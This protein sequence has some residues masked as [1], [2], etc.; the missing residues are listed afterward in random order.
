MEVVEF[1]PPEPTGDNSDF[2]ESILA[3]FGNSLDENNRSLCVVIGTMSQELMDQNLPRTPIAYFGATCSSLDRLLSSSTP[4]YQVASSLLISL[5]FL[6]PSVSPA[7]LNKKLEFLSEILIKALSCDSLSTPAVVSGLKCISHLIIAGSDGNWDTISQMYGVLLR[8]TT[9]SRQKVRRQSELS[10]RDVLQNLRGKSS[11]TPASQGITTMFQKFLLLAG[12]SKADAAEVSGGA[13]DVLHILDTLKECLPHMLLTCTN[14]VLK[15]FK[16]LLELRKP[17]VTRRVTDILSMVCLCPTSQVPPEGLLDLLCFLAHSVSS[18]ETSVDAMT[19]TARLLDSGCKKVH[20]LNRQACVIKLPVMVN[21]FRDIMGSE[22]E[23]AIFAATEAFKN[24][25]IDCIDDKLINQGVDQMRMNTGVG[26][27]KSGPTIIEKICATVESLL[28]YQFSA[29]WD[30][31]LQ[32]VSTTFDKLGSQSAYLMR[33]SLKSLTDLQRLSDE[34]FPY[35]KQ[36]HECVGSALVSM[37]V[38]TF[39][40]LLPLNLE[41]D[42]LSEVN[43][44]L[45]P[46]LKQ[47]TV[48]AYLSYFRDSVLGTIRLIRQKAQKLEL[49][50]HIYSSRNADAIIYSLWSLLPSFC[51]YARDTA[52][53]FDDLKTVLCTTMDEEPDLRVIICS[54][55]QLLIEQNKSVLD[56]NDPSS[57]EFSFSRKR[58][59]AHYSLQVAADNMDVLKSSVR[60]FFPVMSRIFLKSQKDDGGFLQSTIG[61]FSSIADKQGVTW[62]FKSTMKK[63]LKFTEESARRRNSEN[64]SIMQT[65]GSSKDNSLSYAREKHIGLAVS[66]LPGLNQEEISVLFM[67]IQPVLKDKDEG[68][69]QKKAYKAL[70]TIMKNHEGFLMS[71]LEELLKFMVEVRSSC[72]FSARRHRLECLYFLIVSCSKDVSEGTKWESIAFLLA[73]VV[74]AL[75]DANKKTRNRAY[76]ILIE[77]GHACGDEERGGRKE[78][79]L[80]LFNKIA[81]NLT[82]GIPHMISAAVRGLTRLTYE[83]SDLISSSFALLPST[84][85]LSRVGKNREITKANLGLLKVLVAKSQSDGLQTH[86]GSVVTGLLNWQDDTRKHFKSKIKVLLE[87]LIKK[88]GIDAVRAV[89]PEEHMKLLI[90]VRKIKERRER[91][92]TSNSEESKSLHSKATTSR[93]SR[94]NHTNIFSDEDD[95]EVNGTDYMDTETINGRGSKASSVLR[96]NGPA[97]LRSKR[98]RKEAKSLPEDL[99]DQLEDEPL[100][101]LDR[102]KTRSSLKSAS[103]LKRK[104]DSDE[105]MEIDTEGRLI[106]REGEDRPRKRASS[107]SE[108]DMKSEAAFSHGSI[109][110]SRKGQ[111][112]KRKTSDAGWAYTGSEYASKKAKGDLKRKDKLEPYAYWPLDRKMMS[113]RPEHRAKARRGM[114]TVVKMTK[115]LEGKSASGVLRSSQMKRSSKKGSKKKAK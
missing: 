93:L 41:S 32:V 74:V 60:D 55:L 89:M 50:G 113:R 19:F 1:H 12:G 105:E 20:S 63:V 45:F 108:P 46:I 56:G 80:Q 68:L 44:W 30:M 28:D 82:S 85:H 48:G 90:N 92:T 51:N 81:A 35:K 53:V 73:D 114:A 99:L 78:N 102:G 54:S 29:V 72:H 76:G 97:S 100:D 17:V 14:T 79:L 112:K 65:N 25:I 101:L 103:Q 115:M 10:L 86:L 18:E 34:D 11:L 47:H 40:S 42:D 84:F 23:E 109:G 15:N 3:R 94:W 27:S 88:C 52:E 95:S 2:C 37:G 66:L 49:E 13:H 83:F 6:L 5:S 91:K 16:T 70:L 58:A 75:K 96:S 8:L 64:S 69:V 67:A 36:L 24:V 107:P 31:A 104:A 22:H 21:A 87:M 9:D 57:A 106:I 62:L 77:I 26:G 38:E 43:V 59:I 33:G 98:L 7:L 39:L 110:S 111:Q 4:D 61:A 71:N